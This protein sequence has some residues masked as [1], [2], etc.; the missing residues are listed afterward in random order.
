MSDASATDPGGTPAKVA[1]GGTNVTSIPAIEKINSPQTTNN[2]PMSYSRAV[3]TNLPLNPE[4]RT[5]AIVSGLRGIAQ[6]TC[7]RELHDGVPVIFSYHPDPFM[8]GIPVD[9]QVTNVLEVALAL[10]K[11]YQAPFALAVYYESTCAYVSFPSATNRD[12]ALQNPPP[13]RDG[14]L[15]VLPVVRSVGARI[16]ITAENIPIGDIGL[17]LQ[18]LREIFAS[19]GKIIHFS[20]SV[21]TESKLYRAATK[22]IL[23][24]RHDADVDFEIP[25]AAAVNGCNVLFAWSGSPFCYRCAKGDHVK[26]QCPKPHD[27]AL[28]KQP[29]LESPIMGRAFTD[30]NAP[31]REPKGKKRKMSPPGKSE[32]KKPS[33][34][35]ADPLPARGKKTK[36]QDQ[37]SSG[38]SSSSHASGKSAE[39]V[40]TPKKGPGLPP[41]ESTI[42]HD[43]ES[44][45][46]ENQTRAADV[47]SSSAT[48]N[49]GRQEAEYGGTTVPHVVT[50]NSPS[51]PPV[52]AT[53]GSDGSASRTTPPQTLRPEE[54]TTESNSNGT[55][56]P[57]GTENKTPGDTAQQQNAGNEQQEDE[58]HDMSEDEG[59]S[60]YDEDL[61][62]EYSDGGESDS[63]YYENEDMEGIEL[64]AEEEAELNDPNTPHE[65]STYLK[66][67]LDRKLKGRGAGGRTGKS[68]GK[69]KSKKKATE[70]FKAAKAAKAAN[71]KD[72]SKTSKPATRSDQ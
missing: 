53:D 2:P 18:L 12:L 36:S 57:E 28:W 66:L 42:A 22:F 8:I 67:K 29:P 21:N 15:A 5:K 1:D 38:A 37:P 62:M 6:D 4:E 26:N 49:L 3:S 7:W 35:K 16:T 33:V 46:R 40:S 64:T 45:G 60:E 44:I 52:D 47:P 14:H 32:S 50:P 24:V 23:E 56:T 31:L 41:K 34:Q 59:D 10:E 25:R 27:F 69:G 13:F 19:S 9:T 48:Q 11:H 51:N 58:S 63:S 17:R 61:D 43:N 70:K 39:G 20:T 71:R 65:R 30:P 68:K 55:V 72:K 54:E